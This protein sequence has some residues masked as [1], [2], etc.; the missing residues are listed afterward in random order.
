MTFSGH[1]KK[2]NEE[3]F[4]AVR[5]FGSSLRIPSLV[6]IWMKSKLERSKEMW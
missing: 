2:D 6:Q 4:W 3:K 1:Y 5:F